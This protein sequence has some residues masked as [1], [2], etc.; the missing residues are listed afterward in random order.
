[1][2]GCFTPLK[3]YFDKNPMQKDHLYIFVGDLLDR[4]IENYEVIQFM[5]SVSSE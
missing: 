1:M 4:G 2:K 3:Q 5:L